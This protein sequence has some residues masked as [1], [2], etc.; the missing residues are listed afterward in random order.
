MFIIGIAYTILSCITMKNLECV[1]FLLFFAV[2]GSV[3][4]A[5]EKQQPKDNPP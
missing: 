4:K 3:R 1:F 5:Q 2:Y